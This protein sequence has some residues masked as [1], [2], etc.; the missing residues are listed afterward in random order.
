LFRLLD[1][2]PSFP[3]ERQALASFRPQ[4]FAATF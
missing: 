1:V 3:D 4:S 2:S